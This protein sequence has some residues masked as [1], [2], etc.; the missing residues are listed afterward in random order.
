MYKEINVG[1]TVAARPQHSDMLGFSDAAGGLFSAPTCKGFLQ[2]RRHP[3]ALL[4][5]VAAFPGT[6]LPSLCKAP[7]QVLLD[8]SHS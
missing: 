1:L 5:I 2:Q 8:A 4:L 7:Q 3:F 6:C